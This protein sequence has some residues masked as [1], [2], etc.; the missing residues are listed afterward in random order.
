M[1]IA[2]SLEQYLS[3]QGTAYDSLRHERTDCA[4]RSAVASDIPLDQM[5]KGVVLCSRSGY[6][7]AVVPASRQV[8]LDEVGRCIEQPVSLATE[9]EIASLFPDCEHGAVPAIGAPYGLR[10]VLDQSLEEK[11][12]IYFEAGDH[13][14]LV[15]LQGDEFARLTRTAGH[16]R[17]SAGRIDDEQASGYCGA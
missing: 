15:H 10:T 14:T 6:L 7:L 3:S 13:R 17:I 9:T 12:D 11:D 4:A 16:G 2:I 8:R 1:A 5:A